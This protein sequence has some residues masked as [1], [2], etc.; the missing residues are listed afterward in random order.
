M[1]AR[2][3]EENGDVQRKTGA[4]FAGAGSVSQAMIIA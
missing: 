4:A 1:R 3:A 2:L